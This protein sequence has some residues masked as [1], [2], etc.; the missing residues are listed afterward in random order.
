MLI[1]QHQSLVLNVNTVR[2]EEVC[3]NQ[4]GS[5]KYHQGPP[6]LHRCSLPAAW[7]RDGA[8]D[9]LPDLTSRNISRIAGKNEE[10]SRFTHCTFHF[11]HAVLT[12]SKKSSWK[13][14]FDTFWRRASATLWRIASCDFSTE[15]SSLDIYSSSQ[16]LWRSKGSKP[17]GALA[18][19]GP[20]VTMLTVTPQRTSNRPKLLKKSRHCGNNLLRAF[21]GSVNSSFLDSADNVRFYGETAWDFVNCANSCDFFEFLLQGSYI[22]LLGLAI[23]HQQWSQFSR[24]AT[25]P[26]VDLSFWK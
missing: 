6:R 22:W 3:W 10:I 23:Q 5:T 20:L 16:V 9:C 8:G 2:G 13:T 21:I 4:E 24:A 11:P 18:D 7:R 26:V 25:V 1:T 17:S 19:T 14:F 12:R 15:G